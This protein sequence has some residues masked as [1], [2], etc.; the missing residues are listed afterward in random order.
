MLRFG[1]VDKKRNFYLDSEVS[2]FPNFYNTALHST[3]CCLLFNIFNLL[4]K[5][6]GSYKMLIS[7]IS[8]FSVMVG[9]NESVSGKVFD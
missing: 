1:N 5:W 3:F 7:L 6:L 4:S 2:S 9:Q 8:T